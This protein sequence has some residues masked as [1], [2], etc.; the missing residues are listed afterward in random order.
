MEIKIIESAC[1]IFILERECTFPEEFIYFR[2]RSSTQSV[3]NHFIFNSDIYGSAS[4]KFDEFAYELVG[5]ETE[6]ERKRNYVNL[7]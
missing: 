1:G 3:Y 2:N 7:Y 5:S 6:F 4:L